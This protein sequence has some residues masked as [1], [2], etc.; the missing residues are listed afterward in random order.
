MYASLSAPLPCPRLLIYRWVPPRALAVPAAPGRGDSSAGGS[1]RAVTP[2]L[3][4]FLGGH[5]IPHTVY[6][7]RVNV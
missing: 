5:I 7:I 4:S 1:V 3:Q 6:E 2:G